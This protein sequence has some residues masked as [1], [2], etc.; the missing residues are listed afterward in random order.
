[1]LLE[2]DIQSGLTVKI[3]KFF[4]GVAEGGFLLFSL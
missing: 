2:K 3:S 4:E 1:M